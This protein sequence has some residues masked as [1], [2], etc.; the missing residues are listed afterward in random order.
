M[1]RS[2]ILRQI[3][4]DLRSMEIMKPDIWAILQKLQYNKN[5]KK[6]Q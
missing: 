6:D 3:G 4:F 2:M 5:S 1:P